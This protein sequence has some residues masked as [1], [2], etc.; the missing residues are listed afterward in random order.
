MKY[1]LESFEGEKDQGLYIGLGLVWSEEGGEGD[2]E[3]VVRGSVQT[4]HRWTE[5]R[6]KV[7]DEMEIKGCLRSPY[8]NYSLSRR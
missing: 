6:H 1:T 5:Y 2:T 4:T 8:E 7:E 3:L